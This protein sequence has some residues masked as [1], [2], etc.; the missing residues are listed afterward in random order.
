MWRD[1]QGTPGGPRGPTVT[2]GGYDFLAEICRCSLHGRLPKC[3]E[4][5]QPNPT[6][7][8]EMGQACWHSGVSTAGGTGCSHSPAVG[9]AVSLP[10]TPSEAVAPLPQA[11]QPPAPRDSLGSWL[12]E[13]MHSRMESEMPRL[14]AVG[15]GPS[16]DSRA[17]GLT[18]P[19][20]PPAAS[21]LP[22]MPLPRSSW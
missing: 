10:S 7:V 21:E 5:S 18:P 11:G 12:W 2:C 15:R 4:Q 16:R 13:E 8:L 20:G 14:A 6:G 17:G 1:R 22:G 3:E 9:L 19:S